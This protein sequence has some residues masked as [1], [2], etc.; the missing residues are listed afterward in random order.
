MS[1]LAL[2]EDNAR[3]ERQ[4]LIG[5]MEP[6][7]PPRPRLQPPRSKRRR[8]NPARP[9]PARARKNPQHR[10]RPTRR[11]T[12][13]R[14]PNRSQSGV[15]RRTGRA[16]RRHLRQPPRP[17]RHPHRAHRLSPPRRASPGT[18]RQPPALEPKV[19]DRAG[20]IFDRGTTGPFTTDPAPV[21]PGI[22][23]HAPATAVR[24]PITAPSVPT[25]TPKLKVADD[26]GEET[27]LVERAVRRDIAD[28]ALD[29]GAKGRLAPPVAGRVVGRFGEIDGCIK[30]KGLF[31]GPSKRAGRR[32]V[33]WAGAFRRS[34]PQLRADSGHRSRRGYHSLLAGLGRVDVD[35]G[36]GLLAGEPVGVTSSAD[37]AQRPDLYVEIR[38]NGDPIDPL[39]WL[40]LRRNKVNG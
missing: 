35:I 23:S 14:K 10:R 32:P 17:H 22:V 7:S 18:G 38:H 5:L 4:A 29:R 16:L 21:S 27:G 20:R 15:F 19:T 8:P 12:W 37:G 31:F 33:R 25:E 6:P 30:R 36:Q 28:T 34:L 9:W 2:R 24:P 13:W 1:G 11:L 39:P 40:D 3:Q 26:T